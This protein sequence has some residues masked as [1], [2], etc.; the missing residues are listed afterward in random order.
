MPPFPTAHTYCASRE[1]PR[2]PGFFT[3]VP[4]Q[5]EIFFADYN[6]VG[7]VD[8]GKGYGNPKRKLGLTLHFQR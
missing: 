1:G 8:L 4:A 3:A 7:K 6:F 5:K 2:K